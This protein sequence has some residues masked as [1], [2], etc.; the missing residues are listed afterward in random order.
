VRNVRKRIVALLIICVVGA[1]AASLGV[2]AFRATVQSTP[3]GDILLNPSAWV[4][5]TV[6]VE[7]SLSGPFGH[8]AEGAPP[9][10]YEL[11]SNGTIGVLWKGS[12]TQ[13]TSANVRIQGVVR[14]GRTADGLWPSVTCYYIEAETVDIV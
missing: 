2:F 12:D 6:V 7:G 1:V 14:Q 9:Y 8:V 3:V 10:D 5:R 4:N 13:Y 11:S